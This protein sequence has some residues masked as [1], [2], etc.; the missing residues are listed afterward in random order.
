MKNDSEIVEKPSLKSRQRIVLLSASIGVLILF[1]I[2]AL[3]VYRQKTS[4]RASSAR[5]DSSPSSRSG[6]PYQNAVRKVEQDRGE[7]TGNKA[8]IDVPAELKLYKDRNR[9]LAM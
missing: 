2:A 7:P 6:S 9:F 4:M 3:Y 5:D 8:K 1:L